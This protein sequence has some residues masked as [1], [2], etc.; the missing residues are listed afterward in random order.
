M[1]RGIGLQDVA[2]GF[3]ASDEFAQAYGASPSSAQL[4]DK[5]YD[6]ILHR[7]GDA[8]GVAFWMDVLDTGKASVAEVLA[9][10]S[11]SPENQEALAAVIGNGFAYT[12][13]G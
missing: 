3:A 12:P 1:D 6:N 9:A 8:G 7:D 2:A 5:L 11:E 4:V 10:F 13:Y